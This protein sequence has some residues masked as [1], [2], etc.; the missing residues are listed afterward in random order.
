MGDPHVIERIEAWAAAGLIDQSTAVRLH[1]AEAARD[2]GPARDD[3]GR[4]GLNIEI[5]AGEFFAYLGGGFLLAAY[6]WLTGQFGGEQIHLAAGAAIAA[7]VAL[8]AGAWLHGRPG[9]AGRAAGVLVLVAG[10]EAFGA[11]T[12]G[13]LAV[14]SSSALSAIVG[15]MAWL[16]VA[17][18]GRVAAPGL[19][20]QFGWITAFTSLAWSSAERIGFLVF[21][22]QR[23]DP[24]SG[25]Y[26]PEPLRQL[27]LAA[28]LCAAA[29]VLVVVSVREQRAADESGRSAPRR[30]AALTRFWAGLTAICGTASA[31]LTT[32]PVSSS[33]E[34][35]VAE[36][37]VAFVAAVF[38]ALAIRGNALSYLFPAGLGFLAAFTHFNASYAVEGIGVGGALLAEGLALLAV[39][40]LVVV[41]R[42]RIA[43]LPGGPP[44]SSQPEETAILAAPISH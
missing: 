9:A 7:I 12:L 25:T 37:I 1:A 16:A 28:C 19:L 18:L 38:L 43:G 24:M 13:T 35:I 10:S 2:A 5:G 14:D 44:S 15:S 32:S 11:G 6:H 21:G 40:Y 3:T 26:A 33:F 4:R 31:M 22:D 34:A 36:L 17:V 20:S 27:G 41:L 23:F 42:R 39:G 30:R 8:I 29:A